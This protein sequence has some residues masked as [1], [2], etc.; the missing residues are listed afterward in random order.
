MLIVP[1]AAGG[2][3]ARGAMRATSQ[4]YSNNSTS[5]DWGVQRRTR[6]LTAEPSCHNLREK[7]GCELRE[8]RR[9]CG[10]A[11]PRRGQRYYRTGQ[12]SSYVRSL[13]VRLHVG[14]QYLAARKRR[15]YCLD[16]YQPVAGFV[17]GGGGGHDEHA[18]L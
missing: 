6:C 4:F 8:G 13:T 16:L 17:V 18:R 11:R 14:E 2:S 5:A 15:S 9:P 7:Q 1:K 10:T 12:V 3:L